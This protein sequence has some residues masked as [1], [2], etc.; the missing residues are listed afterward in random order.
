M[1][2]VKDIDGLV[3]HIDDTDVR[4]SVEEMGSIL[5]YL[6]AISLKDNHTLDVLERNGFKLS[7][8]DEIMHGI[9]YSDLGDIPLSRFEHVLLS[10]MKNL[11]VQ[12]NI[13]NVEEH[14]KDYRCWKKIDLVEPF[15]YYEFMR[16]I[17]SCE[18]LAS[19]YPNEQFKLT[20]ELKVTLDIATAIMEQ[21]LPTLKYHIEDNFLYILLTDINTFYN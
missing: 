17:G 14:Y 13:D 3:L 9:K 19:I 12:G 21:I 16:W 6:D 20:C 10:L 11:I 7:F 15:S 8:Y 2:A 1:E 4:E 5:T 18:D